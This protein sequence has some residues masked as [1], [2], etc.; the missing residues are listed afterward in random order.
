MLRLNSYLSHYFDRHE[1]SEDLDTVLCSLDQDTFAPLIEKAVLRNAFYSDA[2]RL[3][4][5]D[6]HKLIGEL[7]CKEWNYHD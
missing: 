6:R 2:K 5:A 3:A 1:R 7:G 4:M